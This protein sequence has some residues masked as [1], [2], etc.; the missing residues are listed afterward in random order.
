[1]S[2]ERVTATVGLMLDNC[3]QES[4]AAWRRAGQP[5][6]GPLRMPVISLKMLPEPAPL[7]IEMWTSTGWREASVEL[8]AEHALLSELDLREN[9]LGMCPA[10][11]ADIMFRLEYDRD[12]L[13]PR[14]V[15]GH[16]AVDRL[17]GGPP[18]ENNV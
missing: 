10:H 12:P 14:W 18:E 5:V 11:D 17:F 15:T 4:V 3:T 9:V 13:D 8:A 7:R 6:Y 16:D 2:V 1:M